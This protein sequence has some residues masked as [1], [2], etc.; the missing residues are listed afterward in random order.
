MN[1]IFNRIYSLGVPDK[2]QILKIPGKLCLD[3]DLDFN[4]KE[5]LILW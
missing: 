2:N 5:D 3:V 1:T 4:G